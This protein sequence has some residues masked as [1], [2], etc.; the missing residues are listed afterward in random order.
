MTITIPANYCLD[1]TQSGHRMMRCMQTKTVN[2]VKVQCIKRFRVASLPIQ[3]DHVYPIVLA[4]RVVD[5]ETAKNKIIDATSTLIAACNMST[6]SSTNKAMMELITSCI[7]IGQKFHNVP[8]FN[9][10]PKINPTTV[11]N[12]ILKI[13]EYIKI[14]ELQP[15]NKVFST[16]MLDASTMV[17]KKILCIMLSPN[18]Q[19][20]KPTTYDSILAPKLGVE[21]FKAIHQKGR[22]RRGKGKKKEKKG[23]EKRT[24]KIES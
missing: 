13:G 6:T 1:G 18:D 21:D 24:T 8:M 15:F 19:S 2:G 14:E 17:H 3:H 10:V 4:N 11:S 5:T 7:F 9:L 22:W 16:L 23:G 20:T 12:A